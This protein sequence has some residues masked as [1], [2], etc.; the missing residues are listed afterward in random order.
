VLRRLAR[1]VLLDNRRSQEPEPLQSWIRAF[2]VL[3]WR[4]VAGA[5]PARAGKLAVACHAQRRGS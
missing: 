3:S 2:R 1:P 5:C 4:R